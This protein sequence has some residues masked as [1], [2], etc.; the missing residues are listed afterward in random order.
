[1]YAMRHVRQT[2]MLSTVLAVALT[3]SSCNRTAAP[4]GDSGWPS[5]GLNNSEDRFSPLAQIN[6]S[7]VSKLGLAWSMDLPPQARTL[8]ATPLE[9]DGT[10][11]FTTS[12]SVVYA[13][14]AVT[15]KQLWTYDPESWKHRPQAFRSTEGYH[16]GVAYSNGAVFVGASD[17][18]LI[19]LDAKTGKENWITNTVEGPN[20][21]KQISGAPRVFNGKVIIGNGG[22]DVGTRGYV[23]AYDQKTGKQVWRFYTVPR[24]PREGPQEN[25]VLEKA[26]KTW[27]GEWYKW[28]GGGTVW[29]AITFDPELNRIYFGTGNSSNYDP[30]QRNP[31]NLDNLFLAS[32][33]AVDADTGKY[34]WHYQVNPNEAWDYKATMDIITANVSIDGKPRKVLMQAPSNG[35]FYLIDRE[36]GKLISAEKLG[37]V[38]WADRIDLKTGRPVE[39]PNIRYEKGASTFWP[40]S[41]GLHSWH[42]MSYS[43]KTGL[44]YVPIMKLPGKFDSNDEERAEA[45][46]MVVGS[47]RYWFPMGGGVVGAPKIDP[48]DGTGELVAW[49]P[50]TQKAKWRVQHKGF[51]NGGT[52]VTEGNLV[53]QATSDGIL[54]AYNAENGK[55]VWTYNLRNGAVAPPITYSIKGVQYITLLVGYGGATPPGGKMMDPGWR[56]GK[57]TPRVLTFKLDGKAQLP[58]TPGPSFEVNAI[59]DPKLPI[60]E[61]SAKRG[62]R[63]WGHTCQVCHGLAGVGAGPVAPDLR[64]SAAAHDYDTLR[65][66][67]IDGALVQGGMP[68]YDD[69][70]D[71]EVKDLHMYIRK[72]SRDAAKKGPAK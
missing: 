51:W 50:L 25:P 60:D 8:E 61:A 71:Q 7:S 18:R 17:G 11:Y 12:L 26:L 44:A 47:K 31:K 9:V 45:D 14:D 15:G 65:S 29:N 10:L 28:G 62:E 49:D 22:A 32:I 13:V 27:S 70:T 30:K 24:D 63:I 20:S 46:K 4:V 34:I 39:K 69:R 33:V 59:D 57:H 23:T 42:A 5:Y 52:L 38:T 54:H 67:L 55:E 3:L 21:R 19:S 40:S 56:Y 68:Q 41:W 35:F 1:M 2:A 66:V 37:K 72:I 48:D 58:E 53:F 43:P 16:R 36:T 6:E 64:E